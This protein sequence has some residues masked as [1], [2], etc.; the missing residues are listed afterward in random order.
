MS[1]YKLADILAQEIP[2]HV[3]LDIALHLQANDNRC[4][5]G[6]APQLS[7]SFDRPANSGNAAERPG[8]SGDS[9]RR[10]PR[11]HGG[12]FHGKLHD[13]SERLDALRNWCRAAATVSRETAASL[14]ID[15]CLAGTLDGQPG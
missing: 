14:M 4:A 3:M 9:S 7:N 8:R 15:L 10:L 13:G 6:Q 1:L 11:P 12:K 5:S 2:D